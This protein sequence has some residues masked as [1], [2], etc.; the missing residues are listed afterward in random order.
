MGRKGA[1]E[2]RQLSQDEFDYQREYTNEQRAER[3]A[4]K[5]QL[6][7]E[8]LRLYNE[9]FGYQLPQQKRDQILGGSVRSARAPFENAAS[10]ATARQARTRNS[11]GYGALQGELARNKSRSIAD[12]TRRATTD[13]NLFE[14]EEGQRRRMGGLAGLASLFGID[15]QLLASQMGGANRA[16]GSYSAGIEPGKWET[17]MN[18]I[19]GG[20]SSA[21]GAYFGAKP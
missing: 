20:A 13:L 14:E 17:I 15:T 19:I 16:L 8:Y 12:V 9:S 5:E 4:G 6:M 18:P 3:K 2:Q 11:A 1:K 10:Q 21:A 7:P